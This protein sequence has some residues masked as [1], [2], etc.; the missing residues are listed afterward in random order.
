MENYP[1][2]PA[3]IKTATHADIPILIQNRIDFFRGMGHTISDEEERLAKQNLK[4]S[5]EKELNEN[6]FV[7][8]IKTDENLIISCAYLVIEENLYHPKY[9]TGKTGTIKNVYTHPD[10]RRMGYSKMIILEIIEFAEKLKLESLLLTASEDGYPLYKILG[11]TD[12]YFPNP[13][14]ELKL[15]RTE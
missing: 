14:M 15:P 9:P 13:P 8:L 2:T 10:Y 3:D 5:Y 7:Y 11:F 1:F 12:Q 6:L 4:N